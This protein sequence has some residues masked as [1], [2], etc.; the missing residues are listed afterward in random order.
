MS[1]YKL[2]NVSHEIYKLRVKVPSKITS[3]RKWNQK[4]FE[5]CM[6]EQTLWKQEDFRDLPFDS[7]YCFKT[8]LPHILKTEEFAWIDAEQ[9]IKAAMRES[10]MVVC[11]WE[12]SAVIGP[13]FETT[14]LGK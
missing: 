8:T 1:T 2:F 9:S 11:H 6:E 7:E 12:L 13:A 3:N 14:V 5:E 10:N 4:K